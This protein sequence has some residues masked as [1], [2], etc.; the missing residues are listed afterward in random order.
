M[1]LSA[2]QSAGKKIVSSGLVMNFDAAHKRSYPG[3]GTTWT[4]LQNGYTGT[5]FNSPTFNSTNGGTLVFS[6]SNRIDITTN[7]NNFTAGITIE[8]WVYATSTLDFARICELGNGVRTNNIGF[9]RLNSNNFLGVFFQYPDG[10]NATL[11][12]GVNNVYTLNTWHNFAFTANG[13]NWKL[14]KNGSEVATA[15]QSYLP[16]NT[17]R[18]INTIA[19]TSGSYREY[20]TGRIPIVRIYNRGLTAT[21]IDQNFKALR[22]RYEL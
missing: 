13:T 15:V 7:L 2:I 12:I 3:T 6:G 4:D 10:V 19:S 20:F 9:F 18:A 21:E 17:T 11:D 16:T 1:M 22:A 8:A 5:L 14:Y